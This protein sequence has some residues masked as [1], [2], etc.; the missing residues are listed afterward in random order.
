VGRS[1]SKNHQREALARLYHIPIPPQKDLPISWNIAPSQD[2]P[3]IRFRPKTGLRSL[4]TLR[5]GLVPYWAKD[6]KIGFKTINAR[7]ETVDRPQSR[8]CSRRAYVLPVLAE[9]FWAVQMAAW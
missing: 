8:L 2:V 3:A 1:L 9:Q 7:V 4:D 6:A 5:W